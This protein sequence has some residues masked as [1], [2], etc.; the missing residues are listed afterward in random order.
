MA[1]ML[2]EQRE[3][4]AK[5]GGLRTLSRIWLGL[6]RIGFGA[7]VAG[8]PEDMLGRVPSA[9][10]GGSGR[11]GRVRREGFKNSSSCSCKVMLVCG[12]H[13]KDQREG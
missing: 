9:C 6:G 13:D 8:I 3:R 1:Q 12:I 2:S 11:D 4:A 10:N 7:W 5:L